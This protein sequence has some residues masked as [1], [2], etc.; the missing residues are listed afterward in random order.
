M[1]KEIGLRVRRV[2]GLLGKGLVGLVLVYAA[3]GMIGGSIPANASWV[4]P[5]VGVRIFIEDNG[6]HTGIVM[7]ASEAGVDWRATFPASDLAD[8]RYAGFD[9][10]AVGWGDRA[11][12][13]ETP[14]WG[15]INPVVVLRAAI[16]S[17]RTVLHVEHVPAPPTGNAVRAIML[18]P[19]QYRRLAAF[20][21]GTLGTGGKVASGYGPDD[22]F[23]DARGTYNAAATCNEWTGRALRHAGVR[24]GA[25]TPF[26]ATV[27][28][29]F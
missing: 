26:P 15:D 10:V 11:F 14:T 18:T 22:A 27:M 17:S 4:Q 19:D 3:A 6:I 16:G 12:Y 5:S 1:A 7:P 9:H 8:P 29:W 23:Y 20:V 28:G 21:R 2:A 25:W 24:V 13:V